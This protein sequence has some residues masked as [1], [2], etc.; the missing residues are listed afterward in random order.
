MNIQSLISACRLWVKGNFLTGVKK[1]ITAEKLRLHNERILTIVEAI[2]DKANEGVIGTITT[3]TSADDLNNAGT[4]PDGVYRAQ[5]N[6]LY[7]FEPGIFIVEG[8]PQNIIPEGYDVK[9]QKKDG[10]WSPASI[11][12]AP[13]YDDSDLRN[14]I[15]DI[16]NTKLP[17]KVDKVTGK[18]LST[19]DFTDV[20]KGKVDKISTFGDGTKLL[21]DNGEY[22]PAFNDTDLKNQIKNIN[23]VELPKKV[24]KIDGKGLSTYDYNLSAVKEVE[25]IKDKVDKE[26]GKMLSTNDY[27]NEAVIEVGKI[28]NK[29]DSVEGK[30]LSTNDYTT[31]DKQAVSTIENK[32]DK[33]EGKDLSS[34]DF[35]SAHKNKVDKI[36]ITGEGKKILADNGEYVA[37]NSIGGGF[38]NVSK[39]FPI[40]GFYSLETAIVAVGKDA[41]LDAES[42]KGMI[43]TFESESNVWVDFRFLGTT[44]AELKE[45]Q[46]W[47]PQSVRNVVKSIDL[48]KGVDKSTL[49][50]DENGNIVI[51]IPVVEI[52]ETLEENSTNAA[53]SG[54]VWAAFNSLEATYGASIKLNVI[55]EGNYSLSLLDAKG[56]EISTTETFSGGGGGGGT[57]VNVKAVL[58]KRS[59]N[60]TLKS[61]DKAELTFFYDQQNEKGESTGIGATA[62]VTIARGATNHT[63]TL[64]LPADSTKTIDVTQYIAVG[65]SNVRV[66][67]VTNDEYQQ[68]ATIAWTV[69][70]VQLKLE[71]SFN[72]ATQTIKGTNITIPYALTG[73]GTKTLEL[74]LNGV[75]VDDKT[76]TSSSSTGS[77]SIA[78]TNMT[79]SVQAVQMRSKLELNNGQIIY[80]NTIYFGVIVIDPSRTTTLVATRFDYPDGRI[81]ATNTPPTLVV[82]QYS[83][84]SIIF[85]AYTPEKVFTDVVVNIDN[86]AISKTSVRFARTEIEARAY[87]SGTFNASIVAGT[88]TSA[89]TIEVLKLG[90]DLVEPTNGL[91]LKLNS[92]GRSN[93]DVNREEWKF[94]NIDTKFENFT[95]VGD[96]WLNG[97]LRLLGSAKATINFTPLAQGIINENAFTFSTRLKVSASSDSTTEIMKC[98]DADGVGFVIT[99]QEARMV[100]K[101]NSVVTTKFA[102]GKEYNIGFVSFPV[103]SPDAT[104]YEKT[105]SSMLYLY[106][107]G[108][109]SGGI[110]RGDVDQVYQAT[111]AK[112]TIAPVGK[113]TIDLFAVRSYNRALTDAE[114]LNNYL[115]DLVD[116]EILT[117]KFL[118]NNILNSE[119]NIS[120]D[121]LPKYLPYMI[122]TG[123]AENNR[124]MVLEAAAINNKDAKYDVDEILF[125]NPLD[126]SMN[127]KNVG[128]CIRLQG[129]SS[130]AYPVKNYRIYF[131]NAN[132]VNGVLSQ[133]V[134]K[135]GAGGTIIDTNKYS[136]RK[137]TANQKAAIPVDCFCLKADYAESSSSHNTGTARIV[138]EVNSTTGDITP[139]QKLVSTDYQ[140]D[141]RTTIDG[142]PM[143]L[144]YRE[145]ISDTPKFLS[146]FNFN[147]DKSTEDVF[148]FKDIP[149][150]HDQAWVTSKFGGKNPTECW[151]F[152]NNDYPMGVFKDDDFVT[153]GADG[154]PNWMKVFE[155]RFLGDSTKEALYASGAEQPY[156]L[157]RLVK[158]LKSTDTTATG[159]TETEK[160]QRA[161]KFKN[162]VANYF[163]LPH[164]ANY[165]QFTDILGAVDQRVKNMMLGFWY[166]P[167]KDKVLAY[168]IF[169][170]NDTIMGVRNDGT[171]KYNWD[172]DHNTLDP[173]LSTSDRPVY[174][175]AG[176]QSVLWENLRNQFEDELQKAYTRIR[177]KLTNDYIFKIYNTE[178]SKK[179][180]ERIYNLDAINKYVIPSTKGIEITPGD[181]SSIQKYAYLGLMQGSRASHREW[182]LTN[183]LNLLDAKN[184][185]GLYRSTDLTWKGNSAKG[186]TIKAVAARDYYF[187]FTR[188]SAVLVHQ[189]VTTN[190]EF[191]FT[192]DNEANIG[193]IFHFYGGDWAKKI[194]LSGWGGFT[195]INIPRLKVLEELI[196]GKDG[197]TYVLP[198]LSVGGSLPLLRKFDIRNYTE[199]STLDLSQCSLLEDVNATGC[200]NLSSIKFYSGA[201]LSKLVLPANYKNLTL[202]G[203]PKIKND[204]IKFD[205]IESLETIY[206]DKCDLLNAKAILDLVLAKATSADTK[207]YL[208]VNIGNFSD[209]GTY[210]RRLNSLNLGGL[211]TNGELLDN[212]VSLTGNYQLTN[213][214]PEA[215]LATLKVKFPELNIMR[216]EYTVIEYD[217]LTA[218][219]ANLSNLD[220][221]TGYKFGN[222]Y[223]PSGALEQILNAREKVQL[224]RFG[225]NGYLYYPLDKTKEKRGYLENSNIQ[226]STAS[227]YG[228]TFILEPEIYYKGINDH[229]ANKN[230]VLWAKDKPKDLLFDRVLFSELKSV[231]TAKALDIREDFLN[232]IL[233]SNPVYSVCTLEIKNKTFVRFPSVITTD[234]SLGW[235]FLDASNNIIKKGNT[236]YSKGTMQDG[237][238]VIDSIPSNAVIMKFTILTAQTF[239]PVRL[240]DRN[241]IWALEEWVKEKKRAVFA[242]MIGSPINSGEGGYWA[243]SR[244][245]TYINRTN[246]VSWSKEQALN[247]GA[248]YRGYYNDLNGKGKHF[249]L[250]STINYNVLRHFFYAILGTRNVYDKLGAFVPI[251]FNDGYYSKSIPDPF[252]GVNYSTTKNPITGMTTHLTYDKLGNPIYSGQTNAPVIL[253][254]VN[255]AS[256]IGERIVPEINSVRFPFRVNTYSDIYTVVQ[257]IHSKYLDVYPIRNN[258]VGTLS[259]YYASNAYISN[260]TSQY[261]NIGTYH[262][263][264]ETGVKRS[265]N[266]SVLNED[267]GASIRLISVMDKFTKASSAEVFLGQT[268]IM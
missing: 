33:V 256:I 247:L 169:Y 54:A 217:L 9:F 69:A 204:G 237:M 38:Y 14:K 173:E 124:A 16:N 177:S 262:N 102:E 249:N 50:P 268:E 179:Y 218:D 31:E 104:D 220:N 200:L 93:S 187:A 136:F 111:P 47:T 254:Y 62:T 164:L 18:G 129:T 138:H 143:I 259:T 223:K 101:G 155:A 67:I 166:S 229:L 251:E 85:A 34:N 117:E 84:F 86:V 150:Y 267:N 135:T 82:S 183:R 81:I 44:L 64:D 227:N 184:N 40:E 185:T 52:D 115:I 216:T 41:D 253:G 71:S 206:I 91:L 236:D 46:K 226:I 83:K 230:Y 140:Y 10:L 109:I 261:N 165:Y 127:F 205:N 162:E 128:G 73:S 264:S 139:A 7:K 244:F 87:S 133:G 72:I 263:T 61:G 146:K 246:E 131:K 196:L 197:V 13:H 24:D 222:E 89:F 221:K 122:I 74:Y 145:N 132:K 49:T 8:F 257:T 232:T 208:R 65:T 110:L 99:S 219:P 238:Y 233:I 195:S 193:T 176:R 123:K 134:D 107:D 35:T 181:P 201:P 151:E 103:A 6:G 68:V 105:N 23:E 228:G 43:I 214:L 250:L 158:W 106:V 186:A 51:E 192:Y 141:V 172:I 30:G 242:G 265:M 116:P 202:V 17:S 26:D 239:D 120:V 96:G 153:K 147:N 241:D 48:Y 180:V 224:K 2:E 42:I 76:I 126:P 168:M 225:D 209:D 211:T 77:F 182:W 235:L 213:S 157:Q 243:I 12:R 121:S 175:Y 198:T 45:I 203:L 29:V 149:G 190:Q 245:S 118:E 39:K 255:F 95:W 210:I 142:F 28:K 252:Y 59:E 37:L 32:V 112:I 189:K 234:N 57:I 11:V 188:E 156:Y 130:L 170:D 88:Y 19:N 144:F 199:I 66:R 194:D 248:T 100:T 167:E 231:E 171:L 90:V 212:Q 22:V 80:S 70:V 63:Y 21:S 56:D 114:M 25:K 98:M 119:G 15:N 178:Q 1:N 163:D 148:G 75:L 191:T 5:S 215:E 60:L 160:T 20:Q 92:D 161:A 78:T 97:A 258:T 27:T 240:T 154:V 79:H 94:G 152:L 159:L 174:A 266:T 36:N 108:T 58:E 4:F 113:C 53:Q 55:S 207:K 125:V 3:S 137:A 260:L